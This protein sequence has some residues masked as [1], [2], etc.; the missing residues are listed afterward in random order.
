MSKVMRTLLPIYVIRVK[1]SNDLTLD[2]LVGR[3]IAFELSKFDNF[4]SL[5]IESSFKS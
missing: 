3:L 1:P 2:S 5:A 4:N